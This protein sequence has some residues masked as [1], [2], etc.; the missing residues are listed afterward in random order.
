MVHPNK[1]TFQ[2]KALA[3]ITRDK[4]KTE[5]IQYLHGCCFSPTPCTF[6]RAIKNRNFLTWPGLNIPN[7]NR[8]LP[9]SIATSQGHLDQERT[10]LQSTKLKIPPSINL[11]MT[12]EDEDF[13]PDISNTKTFDVCGTIIPFV[14]TRTGYHD[15]TG[16]FPH[17]SSRGN[18]YIF[19][20][21]II[22]AMQF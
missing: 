8:F 11:T 16:A 14:V 17:K 1:K 22:M 10:N 12:L 3:I 18:Q 9:A 4:T 2:H 15:L 21:M 13:S 5:L 7:I 19:Y 20:F 6:L